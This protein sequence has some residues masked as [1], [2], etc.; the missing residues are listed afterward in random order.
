[1]RTEKEV[2]KDLEKL[3]WSVIYNSATT[4]KL[5]RLEEILS[6]SKAN[7]WYVCR[8]PN[9]DDFDGLSIPIDMQEHELFTIWNWV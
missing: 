7:R 1:M 2:M 5:R 6:I 8:K 4:I 3:G 9:C